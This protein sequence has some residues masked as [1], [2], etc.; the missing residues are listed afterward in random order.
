[1]MKMISGLSDWLEGS[2]SPLVEGGSRQISPRE[3][4]E[5]GK[6]PLDQGQG[7][8]SQKE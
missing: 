7:G 4:K 8:L 5:D 3:P 1:M 2:C 6:N